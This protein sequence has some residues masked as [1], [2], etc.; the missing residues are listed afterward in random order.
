MKPTA[1]KQVSS[2]RRK[3]RKSARPAA[4]R[5]SNQ[6]TSSAAEFFAQAI[7]IE[8]EAAERYRELATQMGN[9]GNQKISRLFETL[10][11]YEE[12]HAIELEH[13]ALGM[14]LPRLPAR[15][16]GWLDAGP[17]EIP[18]YE[19]LYSRVQPHHVLLLALQS[20]RRAREF[21]QRIGER[22]RDAE[23][24]KLA[25]EFARDEA[26]HVNRLERALEN[27]PQPSGDEVPD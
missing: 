1:A 24:S 27:E 4:A 26:D 12:R 6:S 23:V 17:T 10:A 19:L 14:K 9:I 21:F 16:H 3:P 22:S 2:A 20:E 18:R 25:L 13:R 15:A 7:A 11:G 5:E 8:R